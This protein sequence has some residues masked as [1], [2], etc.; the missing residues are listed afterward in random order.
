MH[1]HALCEFVLQIGGE[2]SG[3]LKKLNAD[4]YEGMVQVPMEQLAENVGAFIN[5]LKKD[6]LMFRPDR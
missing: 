4:T 5:Y 1:W 6:V 2:W 3:H